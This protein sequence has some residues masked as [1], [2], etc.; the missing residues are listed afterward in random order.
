MNWGTLITSVL[1]S[2][3]GRIMT[4]I[5]LSFVTVTGFQV[6]QE[7]FVSQM[8]EH[9]GGFPNDV[10]QIAYIMGFGV[11]LNWIFGTFT[12]IATVKGFK[13]LSTTIHSKQ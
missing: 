12:F 13:K 9:I 3:A 5:G 8:I 11:M 6:L 2:V 1:M 7:Y 10:L 4:A